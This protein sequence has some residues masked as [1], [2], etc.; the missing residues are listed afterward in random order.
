MFLKFLDDLELQREE[1]ATLA[2][3]KFAPPSKRHIAGA[4]GRPIRR[5]ITGDELLAFI[6]S[7]EAV[8]PDGTNGPGLFAYLR[9]VSSS[10]G[11]DR[12]DVIATVFKGVDNRMKSGYLLRDIINKVGGHSF[13]LVRRTAHARRAL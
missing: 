9:S 2:G 5:A 3:K 1:E 7:D 8:R 11:D 13:H 12:R 6:N 4:T 10:N